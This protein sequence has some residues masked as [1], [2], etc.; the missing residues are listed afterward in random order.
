MNT[1][2]IIK[3]PKIDD[4]H[5]LPHINLKKKVD[6]KKVANTNQNADFVMKSSLL[7]TPAK[8]NDFLSK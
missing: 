8:D 1:R 3:L 4:L 5:K 2:R 7:K 6:D